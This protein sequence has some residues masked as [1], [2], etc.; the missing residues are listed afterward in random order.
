MK[1]VVSIILS[2]TMALLM[3]MSGVA[4]VSAL[5]SATI[6]GID[7][8]VGETIT[9]TFFVEEFID[10]GT[11]QN[12]AGVYICTFFDQEA[13]E[14]ISVT[15]DGLNGQSV[16]NDNQ[17]N[18]GQIIVTDSLVNGGEGLDISTRAELFTVTFK[19]K[20]ASVS[21]I[22]YYVPYMYDI[23]LNNIS[24]YEFTFDLGV[25][26]GYSIAFNEMP[27]LASDD[28]KRK[29]MD[30]G[31]FENNDYGY[32]YTPIEEEPEYVYDDDD[33][34]N[35]VSPNENIGIPEKAETAKGTAGVSGVLGILLIIG[36][37]FLV[38]LGGIIAIAVP[39]VVIIII[40]VCVKKKKKKALVAKSDMNIANNDNING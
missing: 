37:V 25:K 2:L 33:Y 32:A 24:N 17:N 1:R 9:Y 5:E 28:D 27:M 3:L 22:T 40:V 7:V 39:V 10:D 36:V 11:H 31:D 30:L 15:A 6:N 4:S 35:S 34:A 14:L 8:E 26:D 38:I 29:I 20:S 21:N 13:L 23:E 12:I 19:V 16:I 18:D